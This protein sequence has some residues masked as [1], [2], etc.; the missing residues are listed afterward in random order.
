MISCVVLERPGK[1]RAIGVTLLLTAVW[2]PACPLLWRA[3][4][5]LDVLAESLAGPFLSALK[6]SLYL[7][8]NVAAISLIV[9]LPFGVL[10]ALYEFPGR[11]VLVALSALPL[12]V[13]SFLWAIGWSALATEF[14]PRATALLSGFGG[15]TLVL[16]VGVIPLV[17]LSTFSAT[18][19]LSQAQVDAARLARGEMN[20][21]VHAAR[22]AMTPAILA[23][24]LG[25][26]LAM[27][28]PGP[29]QIFGLRTAAS[30]IL[31]SFSAI[32][33]FALAS[34]QCAVLT[35][36]VLLFAVPL[37]LLCAP[38]IASAMLARQTRPVQRAGHGR[39]P[40]VATASL[41]CFVM[42]GVVVPVVG[43]ILPLAH[44][45]EFGRAVSEIVRT[46][47][48]TATYAVGAG[49]I[50]VLL[51][52][53]TALM[54]GRNPH[55]RKIA[56]VMSFV[57]F[58]LPPAFAALGIVWIASMAPPWIE[59]I[60]R[61]RLTVCLALAVRFFPVAVVLGLRAW[62]STS[63]S[64][65]L[66]AGLHGVS[67]AKYLQR[68]LVPQMLP[69]AG[70]AL[71]LVALLATGDIS[72]ILLLHPPGEA[73]F[74]LALFTVMANAPEALVASLCLAYL[75][76]SAALLVILWR[77]AR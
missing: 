46:A 59:P 57:L 5:S 70:V 19:M 71:L 72:T 34:L 7:G 33:D 35:G 60:L 26:V 29:G 61:S 43:L 68:V 44:G 36:T 74:P 58:S 67:L 6:N 3:S 20:V 64:W 62:G 23:A 31:I 73:S 66:A 28:D 22:H 15:C 13:P 21:L 37:A 41:A 47:S 30:E 24:G 76:G 4:V 56:I 14:G 12:L 48:N 77:L 63:A 2:L 8:F 51:A 69:S 42:I 10:V 27:A 25:G 40:G 16:S 32:Y 1:W 17:L 18:R 38:R 75:S 50:S 52:F 53:L 65:T 54:V 9:G 45:G 55:L 49:V 39:M 11:T